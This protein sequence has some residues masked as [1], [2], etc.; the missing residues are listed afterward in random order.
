MKKFPITINMILEMTILFMGVVGVVLALV[1]SSMYH[2]MTLGSQQQAL[3]ELVELKVHARLSE[4]EIESRNQGIALLNSDGFRTAFQKRD[5]RKLKQILQQRLN[6]L[7]Q[8]DGG[9]NI[10]N[11]TVYSRNFNIR[12]EASQS[13]P[14]DIP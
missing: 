8:Q 11:F 3:Q 4:M 14:V 12:A 7:N 5:N 10:V 9:L 2:S 1:S 13:L 6:D